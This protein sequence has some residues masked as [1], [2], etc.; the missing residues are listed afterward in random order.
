MSPLTLHA[1]RNVQIYVDMGMDNVSLYSVEFEKPFIQA[2]TEYY[3]REAAQ[4]LESEST[5]EYLRKA[6]IRFAQEKKRLKDFLHPSSEPKLLDV[7]N[8]T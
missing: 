5:P 3:L 2:T 8:S 4:W 1:S 7:A 6:E